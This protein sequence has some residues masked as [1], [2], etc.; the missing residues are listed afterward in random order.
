M[1]SAAIEMIKGARK[2]IA[3]RK[4]GKLLIIENN[5]ITI[6]SVGISVI[7]EG[8][9]PTRIPVNNPSHIVMISTLSLVEF[10]IFIRHIIIK[11]IIEKTKLSET[12]EELKDCR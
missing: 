12:I 7:I 4:T 5:T 10:I 3:S 2:T 8:F 1:P 9:S 11:L 6:K